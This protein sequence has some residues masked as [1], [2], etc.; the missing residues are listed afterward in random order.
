MMIIYCYQSYRPCE[1]TKRENEKIRLQFGK[2]LS[3]M[4][5]DLGCLKDE[6]TRYGC[7]HRSV[8]PNIRNS[9]TARSPL[10][11]QLF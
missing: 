9:L 2:T 1:V 8:Q 11:T 10:F 4:V 6:R 5:Y 7:P 3:R